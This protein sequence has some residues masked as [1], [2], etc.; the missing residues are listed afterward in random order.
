MSKKK[1]FI[2][3]IEILSKKMEEIAIR[4]IEKSEFSKL[5]HKQI[6]YLLVID[7]MHNPTLTELAQR[8]DL[9]KPSVTA[10]VTRFIDAG[11]ITKV[12]SDDDRRCAHLHMTLHGH[13]ISK[14]HDQIHRIIAEYLTTNLTSTERKQFLAIL[15]RVV[16]SR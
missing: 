5:T 9:S 6:Y 14:L 8:L 1:D 2:E 4:V 7:E 15:N 12:Q 3:I 13:R 16:D 11:Y 10:L